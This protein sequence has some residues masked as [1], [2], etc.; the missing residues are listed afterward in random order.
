MK[1]N[2]T[3]ILE[4]QILLNKKQKYFKGYTSNFGIINGE[5]SLEEIRKLF[6]SDPNKPLNETNDFIKDRWYAYFDS[7]NF[8]KLKNK[9]IDTSGGCNDGEI[10]NVSTKYLTT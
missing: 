1:K 10:H 3:Y 4:L 5:L 9:L 8:S 2:H 7:I 6:M